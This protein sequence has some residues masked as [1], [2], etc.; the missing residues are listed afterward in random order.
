ML[1]S[2]GDFEVGD[3][4]V[5][6][7]ENRGFTAEELAEMCMKKLMFVSQEAPPPIRDQAMA[8][9]RR[10]EAVVRQYIAQGMESERTSIYNLVLDAGQ[11]QL[12]EA[13]RTTAP[14]WRNTGG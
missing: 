8:Y 10:M 4:T 6:T 11:K 14:K 2:R 1:G 12:A 13:I 7:T 5:K 9:Q 3:V